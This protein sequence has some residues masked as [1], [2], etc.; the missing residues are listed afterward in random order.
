MSLIITLAIDNIDRSNYFYRDILQLPIQRHILQENNQEVLAITQGDSLILLRE[1]S[2]VEAEHPAALQHLQ[3][4]SRGVGVSFD[5]QVDNLE[6]IHHT[7]ERQRL[8]LLY[9]L[10]D[11]EHGIHELWL[12]DPDNYLI[13]LTQS[14]ADTAT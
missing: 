13:I 8:T 1:A 4:Q 11:Q 14:N 9:E 3:R 12:H 5:F 6:Q 10:D 2:E 7:I